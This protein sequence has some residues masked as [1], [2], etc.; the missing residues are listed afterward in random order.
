MVGSFRIL[1]LDAEHLIPGEILA[2]DRI[3][4]IKG[5]AGSRNPLFELVIKGER[6]KGKRNTAEDQQQ[7]QGR[8]QNFFHDYFLFL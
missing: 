5:G 3:Q 7:D 1:I 2:E 8:G 6:G 4:V